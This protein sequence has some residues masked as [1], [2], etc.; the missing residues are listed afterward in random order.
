[1]S[2]AERPEESLIAA[3]GEAVPPARLPPPDA[4]A[5]IRQGLSHAQRGDYERAIIEFTVALQADPGSAAAHVHRGDAHRLQG[6]YDRAV[7]DYSA[8]V[9]LDPRYALAYLNRGMVFRLRGDPE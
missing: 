6:D 5:R 4:A 2:H 7:A 8:A 1:M 9:E 3:N